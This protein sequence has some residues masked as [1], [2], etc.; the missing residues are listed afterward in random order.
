[1]GCGEL[2]HGRFCAKHEGDGKRGSFADA[3]RGSRHQRGY[4][5]A[6][7]RKRARILRRDNFLCQPCYRENRI[8]VAD[9]VDHVI[10]K[11]EGG[12]DDDSN[13]QAINHDCHVIKTR[14]E[15]E[16]GKRRVSA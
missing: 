3:S 8:H 12:T 11:S 5:S 7:D 16:R 4:G 1:M 6:W 9:E 13:L 10:P 2:V 14:A 15:A